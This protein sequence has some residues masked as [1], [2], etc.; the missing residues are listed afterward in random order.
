MSP[1]KSMMPTMKTDQP[2]SIVTSPSNKE[3][4]LTTT[5]VP[6]QN[7]PEPKENNFFDMEY[8]G[9]MFFKY[10]LIYIVIDYIRQK[11][12]VF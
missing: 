6:N 3:T 10:V 4:N 9:R 8:Y 2:P 11:M 5:I 7:N 12:F 1:A